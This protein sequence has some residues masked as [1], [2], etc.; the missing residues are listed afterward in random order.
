MLGPNASA[1]LRFSAP[2][3]ATGEGADQ[4][5]AALH[6][7]IEAIAAAAKARTFP[8]KFEAGETDQVES[9]AVARAVEKAYAPAKAAADVMTAKILSVGNVSVGKLVWSDERSPVTDYNIRR[10]TC[11]ATVNVQYVYMPGP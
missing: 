5:Y 4:K 6:D 3:Y 2:Q 10:M 1:F 9:S 8:E 11:T 7:N